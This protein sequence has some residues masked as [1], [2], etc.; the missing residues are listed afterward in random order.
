MTSSYAVNR[1]GCKSGGTSGE[2]VQE[3]REQQP[4]NQHGAGQGDDEH[5]RAAAPRRPRGLVVT[6]RA[7][8]PSQ[9]HRGVND[10]TAAV[11]PD[12]RDRW[13]AQHSWDASPATVARS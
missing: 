12:V 7:A 9:S 6:D 10:D 8:S 1:S 3:H 13:D 11:V 5:C 4:R 2:P